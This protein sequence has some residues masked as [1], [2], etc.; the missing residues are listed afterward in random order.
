MWRNAEHAFKPWKY[1]EY[2]SIYSYIQLHLKSSSGTNYLKLIFMQYLKQTSMNAWMIVFEGISLGIKFYCLNKSG[3]TPPLS[4]D[5][6]LINMFWLVVWNI[7]HCPIYMGNNH[8]NWHSYFSEGLK[9]STRLCFCIV[10]KHL[11]KFHHYLTSW[12]PWES[13]VFFF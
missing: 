7:F 8:P 3:A 4:S 6:S 5:L 11:G 12:P 2:I 1:D 13:Y 10:Q 9:P